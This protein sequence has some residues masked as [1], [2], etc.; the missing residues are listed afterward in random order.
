MA[1]WRHT[2]GDPLD[3]HNY[4]PVGEDEGC[5]SFLFA[6]ILVVVVMALMAMCS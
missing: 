6:V 5:G 3:Y 1:E 4:E 2:G